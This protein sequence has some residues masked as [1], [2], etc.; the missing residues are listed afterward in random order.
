M[1]PYLVQSALIKRPLNDN[2]G[3]S[4]FE[5][6]SY[7]DM[8]AAEFEFGAR[9]K[10]LISMYCHFNDV[11]I[12][13]HSTITKNDKSLWILSTLPYGKL[14]EYLKH[15]VDLRSG[16][17]TTKGWIKFD[18]ES[19]NFKWNDCDLWWDIEHDTFFS[20]DKIFITK[21]LM[22]HLK[23]TFLVFGMRL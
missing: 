6:V 9:R 5:A 13:K 15:L 19:D 2:V 20:F 1:K 18:I 7:T 21:R 8:G 11:A 17:L 3:K 12:V 23:Q 4:I 14:E 10:A 16:I 22:G